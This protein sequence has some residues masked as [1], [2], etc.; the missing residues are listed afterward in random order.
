[1]FKNAAGTVCKRAE[2]TKRLAFRRRLR[3]RASVPRTCAGC[4]AVLYL[5]VGGHNTREAAS[6]SQN[7]RAMVVG[8]GCRA[9]A[10]LPS[11]APQA[12]T[13]IRRAAKH[14]GACR[15]RCSDAAFTTQRW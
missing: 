3:R 8:G 15:A 13:K 5:S 12:V 10:A 4:S 1:M 9:S 11:A 6:V 7:W 2:C 14:T